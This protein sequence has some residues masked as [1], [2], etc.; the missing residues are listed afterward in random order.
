M[1]LQAVLPAP[2]SGQEPAT[3]TGGNSGE[4]AG[5]DRGAGLCP[6]PSWSAC[7]TAGNCRRRWPGPGALLYLVGEVGEV[8][9]V[10]YATRSATSARH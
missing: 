4:G 7:R 1:P 8:G 9:E 5:P 10:G 2:P 3:A 6:A